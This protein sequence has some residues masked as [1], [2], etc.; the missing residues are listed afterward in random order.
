MAKYDWTK[1]SCKSM[2]AYDIIQS[3]LAFLPTYDPLFTLQ[4]QQIPKTNVFADP[5][6]YPNT[7]CFYTSHIRRLQ[8]AIEKDP[9]NLDRILLFG[10]STS[11]TIKH[12][13]V[14]LNERR[15]S[16]FDISQQLRAK[17]K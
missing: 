5:T 1:K 4:I 7:S 10:T 6:K 11:N 17:R 9:S 8:E 15:R 2:I 14:P 16:Y 3:M 12:I 13:K